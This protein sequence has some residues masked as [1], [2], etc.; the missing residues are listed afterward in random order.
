MN[1]ACTVPVMLQTYCMGLVVLRHWL[2]YLYDIMYIALINDLHCSMM[3]LN[4]FHVH[5]SSMP[6]IFKVAVCVSRQCADK[7]WQKIHGTVS[8]STRVNIDTL[9]F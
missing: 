6:Q 5:H 9:K 7:E 2:I 8:I 4:D 3:S 1:A